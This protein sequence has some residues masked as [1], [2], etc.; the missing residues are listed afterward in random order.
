MFAVCQLFFISII[1]RVIFLQWHCQAAKVN[2]YFFFSHFILWR[3]YLCTRKASFS[4]VK[5][6]HCKASMTASTTLIKSGEFSAIFFRKISLIILL[7]NSVV[8]ASFS[9]QTL[10]PSRRKIFEKIYINKFE[11]NIKTSK[12]YPSDA[13]LLSRSD[14]DLVFPQDN[15]LKPICPDDQEYKL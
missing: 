13:Q 2:K 15:W 7:H 11:L 3:S 8:S 6:M 1:Q 5:L 4:S 12:E 9:L 14:S 10:R